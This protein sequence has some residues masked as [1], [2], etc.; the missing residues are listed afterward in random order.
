MKGIKIWV[1]KII[2]NEF[3]DNIELPIY[4]DHQ[5]NFIFRYSKLHT[6]VFLHLIQVL[7]QLLFVHQIS[8]T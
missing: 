2:S 3:K 7:C 1:Q 4:R 8:H 5:N 6:K